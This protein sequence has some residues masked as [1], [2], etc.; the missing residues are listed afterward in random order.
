MNDKLERALF[1]AAVMTFEELGLMLPT[2]K[3]D[4]GQRGAAAQA[5]VSVQFCGPF[6]GELVVLACGDWLPDL[7]A[8]MLGENEPPSPPHQL[9]A[10]GEIANVICGNVL[11]EIASSRAV[12][13]L[14]APRPVEVPAIA[15]IDPEAPTAKAQIGLDLGRAE[16]RLYLL[17]E[18]A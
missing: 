17:S 9:D 13:N 12:F 14:S 5:A 3:L 6:E 15:A 8:N 2:P 1:Q 4:E 7:A 16:V 10:L 11:P 18:A